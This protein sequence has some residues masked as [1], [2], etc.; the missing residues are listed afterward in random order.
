M[1]KKT[2]VAQIC[3]RVLKSDNCC[4]SYFVKKWSL[5]FT[6]KCKFSPKQSWYFEPPDLTNIINTLILNINSNFNC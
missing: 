2:S 5:W 1:I 3:S 6:E 4:L